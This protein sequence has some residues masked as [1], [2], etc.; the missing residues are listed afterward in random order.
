MQSAEYTTSA[1]KWDGASLKL[2]KMGTLLVMDNVVRDG[3]IA[4]AA[5]VDPSI[6]GTRQMF[7][8]MSRNPRL[9]ATALQTV[10]T[11]GYDGFAMA[12]MRGDP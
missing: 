10:G 4:D 7:E 2:A 6:V 9:S 5:S 1:F 8:L 12:I 3:A 11:K